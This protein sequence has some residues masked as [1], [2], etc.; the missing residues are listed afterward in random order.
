MK[1]SNVTLLLLLSI[2]MLLMFVIAGCSAKVSLKESD[3]P[4]NFVF[5]PYFETVE[6]EFSAGTA[7]AVKLKNIDKPVIVT[8]IHL[9]GPGGGLEEQIDA[10][11]LPDFIIN[12]KFYDLFVDKLSVE[13]NEVLPIS[14]AKPYPSINTDIAAFIISEDSDISTAV[15][16]EGKVQPGEEVWLVAS[17]YSGEPE[18]KKLHRAIVTKSSDEKLKFIYDNNK[19]DLTATSGA[20][21]INDKGQVVGINIGSGNVGDK[22]FGIA[23]PSSSFYNMLENAA[24]D[25]STNK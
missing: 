9:F 24:K 21:I 7:F 10:G 23:N 3:I 12:A 14:D 25:L 1:K 8:A 20:P 4:N 19:I 11:S 22:L 18:G 16:F 15:I 17:V 2:S 6:G 13:S 5:R